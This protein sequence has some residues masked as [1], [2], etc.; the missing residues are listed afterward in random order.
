MVS[1]FLFWTVA[2]LTV[3]PSLALLFARKPTYVAMSM[4]AVMVGIAVAFI[5]LSAP[6]LGLVQIVVYTG[7]V[8]MLFLFVLMLVGVGNTE[9]LKESIAG[10]RWIAVIAAIGLGVIVISATSRAAFGPVGEAVSGEPDVIAHLLFSRYVLAMEVLGA[11]LI[12]AAVGA[13]I[14]TSVPRLLPKRGQEEIMRER[15]KSGADPVNKPMPGVY[16]RHNALDVPAIGP[17]GE[18]L[19]QSVSRVLQARGQMQDEERYLERVNDVDN[20]LPKPPAAEGKKEDES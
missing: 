14:L 1:P 7:A 10:Q 16:A 8:M 13:L 4:V 19:P 9:S 12:T 15:L 5:G 6:F 17:D 3:I 18:P 20:S 11:L 2:F